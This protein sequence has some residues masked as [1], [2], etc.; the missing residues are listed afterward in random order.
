MDT[1]RIG[2]YNAMSDNISIF[3]L[4]R[5]SVPPSP[6]QSFH[7]LIYNPRPQDAKLDIRGSNTRSCLTME[8]RPR[9]SKITAASRGMSATTRIYK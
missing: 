6:P 5:T 4:L 9:P 1:T 7:L 3:L 8:P 2:H